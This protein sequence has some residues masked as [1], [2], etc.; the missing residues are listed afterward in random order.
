MAHARVTVS[1]PPSVASDLEHLSSLLG[2]S[3]SAIVSHV[4][5]DAFLGLVP[6]VDHYFA[7]D[8]EGGES[9]HARRLRGASADVIRQEFATL[10][11]MAADYADPEAFELTSPLDGEG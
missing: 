9:P 6:V 11:R 7:P 10:R 5:S 8:D 1:L 3:R 2:M 4:L